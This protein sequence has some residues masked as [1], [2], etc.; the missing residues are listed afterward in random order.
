[1]AI[2]HI[3]RPYFRRLF[4]TLFILFLFIPFTGSS[5]A[6]DITSEKV[7]RGILWSSRVDNNTFY[8]LGSI[9]VLSKNAYPLAAGIESAYG[10]CETLVF[11]TDLDAMLDPKIQTLIL[12]MGLF[13]KGETLE[14]TIAKETYETFKSRV[15]AHGL[16]VSQFKNFKPWFAALSL[17]ALEFQRLGFQPAYGIDMHFFNRAKKD[18]KK[19]ISLEPL[20]Y[21]L[22]LLGEM[23][24]NDQESFL[25]QTL[26]DLDVIKEML[27]EMVSSW[28]MGDAEKLDSIIRISFK[29]YPHIYEKLIVQRNREWKKRILELRVEKKNTLIIVGAGHLIGPQSLIEMLS[30]EGFIFTQH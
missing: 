21:Q 8:F 19:I 10:D 18:K 15:E 23:N 26:K 16:P 20:D 29:D 14:K 17:I 2:N 1:M 4:L 30:Q 11:E 27:P 28:E 9:H 6:K 22:R 12:E 13:T 24:S 3:K 7:K 5:Y 25:R